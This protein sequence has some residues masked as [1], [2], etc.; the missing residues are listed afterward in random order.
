MAILNFLLKHHATK[1][2]FAMLGLINM[3]LVLSSCATSHKQSIT[4]Y[5]LEHP[6]VKYQQTTDAPTI[7]INTIQI[8]SFYNGRGIVMQTAQYQR[9]T[10]DWNLW[11]D[12]P[13]N[14][15]ARHLTSQLRKALP[16]YLVVNSRES[17]SN[18]IHNNDRAILV[19]IQISRLYGD[20][21]GKAVVSGEI[22]VE[23]KASQ[24][25]SELN[26]FNYTI[27][28]EENGYP[29]LVKAFEKAWFKLGKQVKE[30]VSRNANF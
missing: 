13:D 27:K 18:N 30:L 7:I 16:Q 21:E 22:V 5:Q 15:F 14:M 20:L 9:T 6:A 1:R 10:S 4:Y 2:I 26:H 8:P 28:L 11:A 17:N 19:S 23:N 12:S 24:K 29:G 25:P 3:T